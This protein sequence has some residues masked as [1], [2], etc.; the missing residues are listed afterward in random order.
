[1]VNIHLP[2]LKERKEDIPL[3]AGAFINQLK[4]KS[5]KLISGLHPNVLSYFMGYDWPGNVREL[6]SALEYAFVIAETGLI[7][8]DHLPESF[9]VDRA[10]GHPMP[11]I[12]EQSDG[13]ETS[14]EKQT[15][16]DA[17]HAAGGNKSA[18]AKILG[19]NRMTVWNRMR[20]YGLHLE[21]KVSERML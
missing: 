14:D 11:S 2:P 10:A 16:I 3:L 18:A 8:P 15:L 21:K 13:A 6:K 1:V 17:L 5:G 4:Q 12:P 20:K 7:E 9:Q 19:V